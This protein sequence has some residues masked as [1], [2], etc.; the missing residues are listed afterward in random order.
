MQAKMKVVFLDSKTFSSTISFDKIAEQC[1]E[2][3]CY[4]HTISDE[5]IERCLNAEIV[6]TNKVE[7]TGEIL[8]QL[9]H[10][11]LICVAATG[12]NNIDLLA[13]K[14]LNICVKNVRDY[15]GTSIAQYVFSQLFEHYQHI[16]SHNQNV[17][18]GLWHKN[19]TK[20]QSFCF[21]GNTITELAGKTLGI[22]GYG[23]LGKSVAKVAQAFDM[24]IL[25]SEHKG[26]SKIREGRVSFDYLLQHSDIVSLHC[27]QT[28][29][30]INL[31]DKYALSLMRS[32]T[33]LINTARGTLIDNSALI[34]ALK[35]HQISHA[36]LD[37][38]DQEPPPANHPLLVYQA[39]TLPYSPLTIT[40]HIAWAS[41]QAQQ[42]LIDMIGKNIYHF[43]K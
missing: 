38:L 12:T 6:I 32:N 3:V 27:P 39:T 28:P 16:A 15:A 22:I 18:K 36:F 9:K 14:E 11:K 8:V 43:N 20:K 21:H 5:V 4:D 13:A 29:E 7:L 2:L 10:L 26:E 31:I 35:S 17:K 25:I 19:S 34:N 41:E 33:V 42:R 1:S 24:N 30:T 37:V 23:T 40:A